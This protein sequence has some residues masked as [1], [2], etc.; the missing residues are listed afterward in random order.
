MVSNERGNREGEREQGMGNGRGEQK[1]GRGGGRGQ[2]P[3]GQATGCR[4]VG[5]LPP[6]RI[7]YQHAT[8]AQPVHL[9]SEHG[10]KACVAPFLTR[11]ID[12]FPKLLVKT[13][14]TQTS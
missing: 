6:P 14:L 7:L 2:K 12:G 11:S 4:G 9:L 13:Q 8:W 3:Q 10:C 1:E 5:A